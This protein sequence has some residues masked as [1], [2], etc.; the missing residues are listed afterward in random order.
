MAI[1]KVQKDPNSTTWLTGGPATSLTSAG[2][3]SATTTGNRLVAVAHVY[4]ASGS[5]ASQATF[6]DNGTH[7]WTTTAY[8]IE[9]GGSPR[10]SSQFG[11]SAE[12][13]GRTDHEVTITAPASSYFALGVFEV[14][15]IDSSS[16]VSDSDTG[17]GGGTSLALTAALTLSGGTDLVLATAQH[18]IG[19]LSNTWTSSTTEWTA[20]TD[21]CMSKSSSAASESPTWSSTNTANWCASGV[22]FKPSAGATRKW[23]LGAH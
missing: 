19:T 11:Y 15:G 6:S 10:F 20:S 3:G 5:I 16:P 1:S 7:S 9:S 4:Q 14:S 13:T 21:F 12:I 8:A 2:T 18:D 22:A 17:Q 23:L